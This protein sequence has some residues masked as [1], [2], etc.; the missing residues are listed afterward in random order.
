MKPVG[1]LER[2]PAQER[3]VDD[4][5]ARGVGADPQRQGGDRR[6]RE[7]AIPCDQSRHANLT[8]CRIVVDAGQSARRAMLVRERRHP[9]SFRRAARRA[10]SGDNPRRMFSSVSIAR[11]DANSSSK[12]R[13]SA[14]GARNAR[15]RAAA[16]INRDQGVILFSP[17]GATAGRSRR[18]CVPSCAVSA[19][20]C[21][22]P[23]LESE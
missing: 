12:S 14:S 9:P 3:G 22:R 10:A 17:R 1:I 18:R 20:S 21:R 4:R 16:C 19:T 2:Q 11:C 15:S 23:A 7:P 13:S 8:S 5:E 6:R